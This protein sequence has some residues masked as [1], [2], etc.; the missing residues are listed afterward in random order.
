[1][2]PGGLPVGVGR[3][4]ARELQGRPGDVDLGVGQLSDGVERGA[5]VDQASLPFA[6]AGSGT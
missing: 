6:P 3:V 5:R 2:L 1:M 4:D